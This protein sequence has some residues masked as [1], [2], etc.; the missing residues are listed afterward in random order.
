MKEMR[1]I[2]TLVR[3]CTHLFTF[4]V[5]VFRT[6]CAAILNTHFRAVTSLKVQV[7]S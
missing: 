6:L 5:L 4:F 7:Y 1:D 3:S 2:A